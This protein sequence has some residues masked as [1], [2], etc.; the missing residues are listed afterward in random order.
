MR[1]FSLLEQKSLVLSAFQ[2]HITSVINI[3]LSIL[4]TRQIR[5]PLEFLILSFHIYK[6]KLKSY[7]RLFTNTAIVCD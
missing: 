5:I 2:H 7:Y 6:V 3:I 1:L 4:I